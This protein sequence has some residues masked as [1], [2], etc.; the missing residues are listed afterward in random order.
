M[1]WREDS[2]KG[3]GISFSEVLRIYGFDNFGDIDFVISRFRNFALF[4]AR[5]SGS[6]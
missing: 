5:S 4:S 1:R 6:A 2:L 3:F